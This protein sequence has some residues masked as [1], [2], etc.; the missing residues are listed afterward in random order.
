MRTFIILF[1][2]IFSGTVLSGESYDPTTLVFPPHGHSGGYHKAT[3]HTIRM[4]LG[5]DISFN[6]PQGI[7]LVK[8]NDLDDP[9]T[10]NDDDELTFFAVNSG[11]GQIVYNDGLKDIKV[12]G[13]TGVSQLQ[14]WEP[15]GIASTP[16]G[17]VYVADKNNHRIVHLKYNQGNLE[18]QR[19]IGN[20]LGTAP[21]NLSYPQDVAVDSR[22]NIYI[23]EM[24]NNRI[25]VFDRNGIFQ[26]VIGVGFLNKPFGIAVLDRV[27]PWTYYHDRDFLAVSDA[28]NFRMTIFDLQGNRKKSLDGYDLENEEIYFGYLA[29]DYY[30]M[31]YATDRRNSQIHIFT[32]DLRFITS[33]G[34]EGTGDKEF[35][36][37]RGIAIWKRFGQILILE[38]QSAQYYWLGVDAMIKGAFPDAFSFENPGSTIS[39]Y[40]TQPADITL[41]VYN[42]QGA[43][44]RDLLPQFREVPGFTQVLWDGKDNQGEIV[45]TGEYQVKLIVTPTY[46]S[47]GYFK[48]ELF[49][50]VLCRDSIVN[51]E[52]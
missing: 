18:F 46:S 23:T 19:F 22:G 6:D 11:A 35:H 32:K 7:T 20:G 9:S 26:M 10:H 24:G 29:I 25:S 49:T 33:Y 41:E 34:R 31:V 4:V 40:I 39:V 12:Y 50:T 43:L 52:E 8:L 3:S 37:P 13:S 1:C 21:G 36:S 45:D 38:Q 44:V 30:S 5:N 28:D 48:K 51:P 14:L 15:Q 27:D 16:S 47:K 2:L 42:K 17:D